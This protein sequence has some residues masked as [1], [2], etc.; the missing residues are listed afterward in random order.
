MNKPYV[1]HKEWLIRNLFDE[2]RTNNVIQKDGK[3]VNKNNQKQE[4]VDVK[5]RYYYKKGR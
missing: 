2:G 3:Y 1:S 5:V 4:L